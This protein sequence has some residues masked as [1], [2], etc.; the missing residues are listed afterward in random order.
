MSLSY[1]E[2]RDN[3][4]LRLLTPAIDDFIDRF[5]SSPASSSACPRQTVFFFP[6]GMASR[7]LR[8]TQKFQEGLAAPQQFQYETVWIDLNTLIDE[9]RHLEMHRDSAGGFRDK[10]DYIIVADGSPVSLLGC[11]PHDG[12]INW[13]ASNNAD[14]FVFGWDWRRRLEETA[15]FFVGKFLPFFRARVM[16]AG[17]ADPLARFSLIGHSFG[18]M[19]ANLILRGNDPIVANMTHAITVA[20][21]FYGY[22]GQVHR[23]FEG[24]P[25][26]LAAWGPLGPLFKQHL[27]EV[28]SSMPGLYTLHFLDEV[29]FVNAPIQAGLSGDPD[30]PL[31]YYPSMDQA[32]AALRADAYNPQTNGALVRYPI[33]TGFDLSELAHAKAQFQQLAAPMPSTMSQKFYNIRGVRTQADET[34]AI[35]DTVGKVSWKWIEPNYY[36]LFHDSPIHDENTVAGDDTQPA[37]SARLATNDQNRWISVKASDL[38]HAFMMNHPKTLT[39]IASILCAAQGAAVTTPETPPPASEPASDEE[40]IDFL[41]WLIEHRG[42]MKKR[43]PQLHEEEL[44]RM[45]PARHR[46]RLGS[47]ARRILGDLA[48]GPVRRKATKPGGA[49]PA[50]ARGHGPPAKSAKGRTTGR[51][52]AP[53]RAKAKRAQRPSRKK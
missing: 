17:A 18:G 6:G 1:E 37:W 29:T 52:K 48:R 46:D 27:I 13:C 31:G 21:P 9:W 44:R 7:L 45:V 40:I 26:L 15:G 14:L 12:L 2:T 41:R 28:I 8:A 50:G 5:Q 51:S 22:A 47:I 19:I 49:A 10:G 32:A 53:T 43:F 3:E 23:W 33:N 16:N 11:T 35:S 20:T 38:E 34:T 25:W 30:F 42:K 36:S 39:A 4:Q 24:E